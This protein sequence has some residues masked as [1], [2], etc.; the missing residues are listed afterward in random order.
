[1]K[2][3]LVAFKEWSVCKWDYN[4]ESMRSEGPRLY[5]EHIV[6][7]NN[8]VSE[9][10]AAWGWEYADTPDAYGAEV[11]WKCGTRVPK[12]VVALVVLYNM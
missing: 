11:C 3:I 12:D 8:P 9:E 4:E 5:A 6:G 10:A 2:T 7:C 1:M